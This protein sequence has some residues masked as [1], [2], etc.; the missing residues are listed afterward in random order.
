MTTHNLGYSANPTFLRLRDEA[1]A[2]LPGVQSIMFM[3]LSAG[4]TLVIDGRGIDIDDKRGK[5]I[6]RDEAGRREWSHN[7]IADYLAE[8][9]GR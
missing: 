6:V 2:G 4:F 3:A 9:A 5:V 1:A 8:R 7:T